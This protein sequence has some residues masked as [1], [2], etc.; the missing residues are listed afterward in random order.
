MYLALAI[1]SAGIGY[2]VLAPRRHSAG[3]GLVA[4]ALAGALLCAGW[5]FTQLYRGVPLGDLLHWS[6]PLLVMMAAACGAMGTFVAA[7]R[8]RRR[9]W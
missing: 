7:E 4:G 1:V 3:D 8:R 5:T 6:I 2:T 9:G